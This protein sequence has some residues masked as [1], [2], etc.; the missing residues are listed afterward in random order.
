LSSKEEEG[1]RQR[2]SSMGNR[3]VNAQSS[4]QVQQAF[5]WL[6]H[7]NR[8]LQEGM[9]WKDKWRRGT[10]CLAT[11][12]ELS[13]WRSSKDFKPGCGITTFFPQNKDH[14]GVSVEN[15]F[16]R[17]E[18]LGSGRS[19]KRQAFTIASS[20]QEINPSTSW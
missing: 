20:L 17:G 12:L 2:A 16:K 9:C 5:L 14:S 7:Q 18:R 11:E 1:F 13:S 15:G 10:K 19:L 6:P 4:E 8:G 3:V